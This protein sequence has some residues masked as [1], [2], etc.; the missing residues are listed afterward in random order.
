M[1]RELSSGFVRI[2]GDFRRQ[3]L[4]ITTFVAL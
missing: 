2:G 3:T 1:N 4:K